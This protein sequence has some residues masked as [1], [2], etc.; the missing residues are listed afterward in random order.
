[1]R[2]WHESLIPKLC[3]QHLLAMWREGL[4]A[5]KIITENKKF[6]TTKG[7]EI[8]ISTKDEWLLKWKWHVLPNGYVVRSSNN[9]KF[10]LHRI[11]TDCPG[12]M[13]VDHANGN[14]LDNRREN[15]RVCNISQN[16]TNQKK[17]RGSSKY[18]GVNWDKDRSKWYAS[19]SINNK[20]FNL[21]RFKNEKDAAIVYDSAAKEK[22]G[23]FANLNFK[24]RLNNYRNHPAVKEFEVAL[25]NLGLRLI[26]TKQ[27]MLQR[28][29]K[30]KNIDFNVTVTGLEIERQF[31]LYKPW[32]TLEEQI[33]ILK[34]KNCECK[35]DTI[36]GE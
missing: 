30:P 23:E 32:Q 13:V 14:K 17:S 3:R 36:G 4:G 20:R 24:K 22:W 29:Y 16:T 9:K 15:L 8:T 28:G 27:E 10:Y 35:L 12:N 21:G 6:K 18:K 5:Y 33:V 1:M 11:I 34:G 25:N 31:N 7:E 26:K 19:I 2:I